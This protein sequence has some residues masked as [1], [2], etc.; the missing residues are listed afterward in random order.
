M[1]GL[2]DKIATVAKH[3]LKWAGP[4]GIAAQLGGTVFVKRSRHD[5]AMAALNEAVMKAKDTATSLLIFPE[6]TR[7]IASSDGEYMLPFKKGAFH[8]AVDAGLPI[9]PIVISEY[10]FINRK[11]K[12][13]GSAGNR[14][15][16]LTILDPIETSE[17][18]KYDIN[19]LVERSRSEMIKIFKSQKD[20]KSINGQNQHIKSE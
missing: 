1:W 18:K 19:D 6:G 3:E 13:F 2:F 14:K 17:L 5:K 4:F 16:T 9:L 20:K 12:T 10:D 8:M 11:E 7:H 15:V